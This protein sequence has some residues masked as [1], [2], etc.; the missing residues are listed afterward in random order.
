MKNSRRPWFGDLC[1][2]ATLLYWGSLAYLSGEILYR[3]FGLHQRL[4]Q[5]PPLAMWIVVGLNGILL[6]Q[7]IRKIR[8]T[9]SL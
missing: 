8:A 4:Y 6:V 1:R 3:S 9:A 2:L 5:A 7:R